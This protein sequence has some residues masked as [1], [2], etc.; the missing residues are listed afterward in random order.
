M[1]DLHVK[2]AKLLLHNAIRRFSESGTILAQ[3]VPPVDVP[4]LAKPLY[5]DDDI[6]TD[7]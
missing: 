7:S 4:K 5:G 1:A 6:D 3:A 2:T